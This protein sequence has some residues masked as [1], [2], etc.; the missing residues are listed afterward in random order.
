[1]P[2][3]Y[4]QVTTRTTMFKTVTFLLFSQLAVGGLISIAFVPDPA[5]KRFFRFCGAACAILMTVALFVSSIPFAVAIW[6]GIC[7]IATG[8]F[9]LLIQQDQLSIAR[10]AL[11]AAAGSGCV[12]LAANALLVSS[13]EMPMWV[14]AGSVVYQISGAAF[15]GSVIFGMTL[16]HWYLIVPTLPIEPLRRL[17]LLMI[18]TTCIRTVLLIVVLVLGASSQIPEIS[19]T[20]DSFSRLAGLFFWARTLF[21]ILGPIAIC[22]MTWETVKLNATQSATGL[23]YV[24][25]IL[26]LIGE[27]M[28]LYLYHSTHLPV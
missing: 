11:V 12:G 20:I 7:L 13:S 15:I 1:M 9:V 5:G 18:I 23:L 25:T 16:G 17:T 2:N 3:P 28:S 21:G 24:A 27:T 22:Y 6:L 10:K 4:I 14:S 26:V 19:A 8:L